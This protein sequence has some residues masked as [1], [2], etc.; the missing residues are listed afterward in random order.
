MTGSV[1]SMGA[2]YPPLS[3]AQRDVVIAAFAGLSQRDRMAPVATLHPSQ[4]R[5]A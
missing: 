1:S 4:P 2:Q 5:A 3:P